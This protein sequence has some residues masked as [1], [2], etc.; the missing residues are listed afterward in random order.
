MQ[1]RIRHVTLTVLILIAALLA[2]CNDWDG[3]DRSS[4]GGAP[5]ATPYANPYGAELDLHDRR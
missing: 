2:G 5:T 4:F 1:S 3:M